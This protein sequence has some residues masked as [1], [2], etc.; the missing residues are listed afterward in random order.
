M[1][2][3]YYK[4]LKDKYDD[5]IKGNEL[6]TIPEAIDAVKSRMISLL[7]TNMGTQRVIG[8]SRER[9]EEALKSLQIGPN[10]KDKHIIGY[11]VVY[12]GRS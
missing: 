3:K 12:R 10:M 4:A 11:S 9:M 7:T 1:D 2:A 5:Y 8:V 6:L